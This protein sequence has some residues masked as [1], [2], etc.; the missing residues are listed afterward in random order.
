M[1]IATVMEL[2]GT[3]G[4]GARVADTIRTKI[5]K[6]DEFTDSPGVLMLGTLCTVVGSSSWL[7]FA[8][9]IGSP[10]RLRIPSSAVP[11]AWVSPRL[12]PTASPGLALAPAPI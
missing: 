8:T 6:V 10:S 5:V 9:K 12:A 1:C 4:V 2:A 7:I 3:I 11:S